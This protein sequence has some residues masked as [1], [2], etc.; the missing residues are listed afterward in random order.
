MALARSESFSRRILCART[1]SLPC[2]V[3]FRGIF[4]IITDQVCNQSVS[5]DGGFFLCV[6]SPKEIGRLLRLSNYAIT[7]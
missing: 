2:W 5:R 6:G 4:T 1:I 7:S 3:V